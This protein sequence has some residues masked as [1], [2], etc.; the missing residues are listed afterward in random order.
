MYKIVFFIVTITVFNLKVNA[1]LTLKLKYPKCDLINT[2]VLSESKDNQLFMIANQD[3]FD[4]LFTIKDDSKINF[5]KSVAL[6]AIL[7]NSNKGNY[8]YIDAASFIPEKRRL[9]VRWDYRND[10]FKEVN[11]D[12]ES[13]EYCV[14]VVQKMNYKKVVFLKG[15]SYGIRHNMRD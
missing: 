2:S 8:I 5:E 1:Q 15:K 3:E 11:T 14:V 9:L 7:G 13:G 4:K 12:N 6:V 10:F